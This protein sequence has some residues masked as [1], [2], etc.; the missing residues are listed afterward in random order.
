MLW[1]TLI[2]YGIAAISIIT[3]LVIAVKAV[4]FYKEN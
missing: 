3:V 1:F 4:A 2:T